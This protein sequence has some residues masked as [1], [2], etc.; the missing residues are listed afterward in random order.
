MDD[1]AK[2]RSGEVVEVAQ[3]GSNDFEISKEYGKPPWWSYIWVC[4][5]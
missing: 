2:L 1:D 3:V 5:T 4:C